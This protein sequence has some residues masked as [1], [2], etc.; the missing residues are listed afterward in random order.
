MCDEPEI[1]QQVR[2]DESAEHF[3]PRTLTLEH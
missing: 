1:P 3:I 2:N